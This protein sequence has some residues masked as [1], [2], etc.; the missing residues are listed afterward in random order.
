[1]GLYQQ[2]DTVRLIG[3]FTDLN[4]A[5]ADPDTVTL[6]VLPPTGVAVSYT[7]A[8]AEVT[9]DDVGRYHY[10]LPLTFSG[11]WL[12]RWVGTGAV[13]AATEDT[14]IRVQATALA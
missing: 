8:L 14:L 10:D 3:A 4:N 9:K 7:Y 12:Y 6:R 5:P 13:A 1:M 11:E 2:G